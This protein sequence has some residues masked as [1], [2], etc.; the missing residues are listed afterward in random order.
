MLIKSAHRLRPYSHRSHTFCLIPGTELGAEICPAFLRVFELASEKIVDERF[1]S[2]GLVE[3]FTVTQNLEKGF[4]EVSGV[5]RKGHEHYRLDQAAPNFF[6][7][8]RER[9]FLGCNKAQD[10]EHMWRRADLAELMP[11]WFFL[12]Q[13]VP[14]VV[15]EGTFSTP[16]LYTEALQII[17][18]RNKEAVYEAL[19]SLAKAGFKSLFFPRLIDDD[20][21]GFELP[22]LGSEE[23]SPLAVLQKTYPLLRSCFFQEAKNLFSILPV[24]PKEFHSGRLIDLHTSAGHTIHLEWTK[25]SIRRLVIEANKD[26]YYAFKFHPDIKRFRLT[27]LQ[28]G[29]RSQHVNGAEI[30]LQGGT[31]YLL[32]CFEG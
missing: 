18:E 24:L 29:K 13:S 8:S 3:A 9:L 14:K 22:I 10:I 7:I 19:L 1:F 21:Q 30:A 4:V 28:E 16:S 12:A 11:F 25:K 6:S 2:S 26:D 23:A 27:T 5:T 31:S 17:E 32:D 15:C 20:L